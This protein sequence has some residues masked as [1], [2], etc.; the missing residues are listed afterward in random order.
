MLLI[1]KPSI[2]MGHLYH[3]YVS[4]NQVGYIQKYPMFPDLKIPWDA[5]PKRSLT[6]KVLI[7][8]ELGSAAMD[9]A[10]K[11]PTG[12]AQ[13]ARWRIA[14]KARPVLKY[15]IIHIPSEVDMGGN[16]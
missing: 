2:S 1:G 10:S 5:L 7:I 14:Q 11:Q 4:H 13:G 6:S 15:I 3:G 16:H 8:V 12:E 9:F